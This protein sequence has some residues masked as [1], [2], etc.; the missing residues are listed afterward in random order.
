MFSSLSTC[1]ER[2][3]YSWPAANISVNTAGGGPLTTETMTPGA[4]LG[5]LALRGEGWRC[6]Y[7]LA[8]AFRPPGAG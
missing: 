7:S 4:G 1:A 6:G 5:A 3:S 2:V 8:R